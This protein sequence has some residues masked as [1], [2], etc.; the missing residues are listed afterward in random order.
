MYDAFNAYSGLDSEQRNLQK[1]F[2][3]VRE[4]ISSLVKKGFDQFHPLQLHSD[5]LYSMDKD[6]FIAEK[7]DKFVL[8]KPQ[9][10]KRK[11]TKATPVK[12]KTKTT[13]RKKTK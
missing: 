3:L 8:S 10:M 2:H 11:T 4:A 1:D 9:P 12:T 6:G 13:T 5:K 7:Y